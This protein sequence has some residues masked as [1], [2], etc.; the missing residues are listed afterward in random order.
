MPG[1]SAT[2]PPG[3]PPPPPPPQPLSS[4]PPQP[5]PPPKPQNIP[6]QASLPHLPVTVI[7]S[8]ALPGTSSVSVTR[9]S[10]AWLTLPPPPIQPSAITAANVVNRFTVPSPIRLIVFSK[11][12][13][14]RHACLPSKTLTVNE[15]SR[16]AY[17]GCR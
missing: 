4:Q 13:S 10:L 16:Q 2:K 17:I 7:P 5:Q 1:F 11:R 3:P 9:G 8:H 14:I 12:G 15:N 6:T